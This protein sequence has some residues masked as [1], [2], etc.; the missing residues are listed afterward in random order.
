MHCIVSK[1]VPLL[2]MQD[3]RDSRVVTHQELL[4]CAS[5]D[6]NFL[7]RI[8]TGN[9]TWVYGYDVETKTQSSQWVGKNSP[10]MKKAWRVRSNMNVMLTVF[11]HRGCCPS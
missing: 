9:E 5:E 3:Q 2:L 11:L 7:K 10:R 6:E 1:F 8:I 4:D